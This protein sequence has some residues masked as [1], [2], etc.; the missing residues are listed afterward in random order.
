MDDQV[1]YIKRPRKIN[2]WLEMEIGITG[3]KE[4]GVYN[5]NIDPEKLYTIPEHVYSVCEALSK[6]SPMFSIAAAFRNFHG[7]YKPGNVKLSPE[8]RGNYHSLY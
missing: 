3:G 8:K 1:E 2:I 5:K 4:D 6:I 7:V